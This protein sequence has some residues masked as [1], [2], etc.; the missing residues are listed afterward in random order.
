MRDKIY[1]FF[2]GF[3]TGVAA[4]FAYTLFLVY[5]GVSRIN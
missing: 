1:W 4:W 2:A 5:D 3:L